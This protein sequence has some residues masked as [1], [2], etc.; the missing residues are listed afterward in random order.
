MDWRGDIRIS[1]K[2]TLC[3]SKLRLVVCGCNTGIWEIY[4]KPC[5]FGVVGNCLYRTDGGRF[6]MAQPFDEDNCQCGSHYYE[7]RCQQMAG[8]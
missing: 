7:L 5:A 4:W 3:V 1:Y 6:E 8:I 2:Q